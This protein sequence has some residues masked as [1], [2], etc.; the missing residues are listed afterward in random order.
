MVGIGDPVAEKFKVP[1][2]KFK[3]SALL[4]FPLV[5]WNLEL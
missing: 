1:S 5:T 3:S 4:Y 2:S